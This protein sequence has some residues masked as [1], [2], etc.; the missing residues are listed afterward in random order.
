MGS[1]DWDFSTLAYVWEYRTGL[2]LPG[3]PESADQS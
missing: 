1:I 2:T 3:M